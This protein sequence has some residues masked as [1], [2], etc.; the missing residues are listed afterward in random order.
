MNKPSRIICIPERKKRGIAR[1]TIAI[2]MFVALSSSSVTSPALAQAT[3]SQKCSD[4]SVVTVSTG[5]SGGE[6]P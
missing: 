5:N 2:F 1:L 6:C 3:V 4:G